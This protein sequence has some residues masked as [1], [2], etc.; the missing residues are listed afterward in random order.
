MSV[1]NEVRA[2]SEKF[3]SALNRMAKGEAGTMADVWSHGVQ[4]TAFHPIG[5]RDIGWDKVG[6]SFE[7]VAKI[8]SDGQIKLVDQIIQASGDMAC[9]TGTEKGHLTLAGL[10]ANI[11]QRVTNI[12]RK[13]NGTWKMVHHHADISSSM[14]D[15]LARLKANA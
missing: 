3:Y 1:D 8:A 11:D 7:N 2:A 13:E 15:V 9:E 4:V 12:Y 14:M 10:Q 5:G 6:A